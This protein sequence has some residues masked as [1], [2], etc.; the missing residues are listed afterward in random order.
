VDGLSG[1]QP[2]ELLNSISRL[3]PKGG[4]NLE[5]A[6]NQAYRT[7]A[8]FHN[9]QYSSRVI[10]LTDGAAN[11]G[12]IAPE[13]LTRL[14]ETQRRNGIAL[15]CFGIGWQGFNDTLLEEL[16]RNG[17]GR[18]GFL[19]SLEEVNTEFAEKLAGAF[20]PAASDVKVQIEFNPQRVKSHRLIGYANHRL[21]KEQFRDNTVDAA[22]LGSNESGN[23]LY[24]LETD[25]NGSGPISTMHLRYRIPGTEQYVESSR[26]LPFEAEVPALRD[27][28]E[29]LRLAAV[30]GVFGEWLAG[31]PFTEG[32]TLPSLAD[33]L[34]GVPEAFPYETRPQQLVWMIQKTS[35]LTGK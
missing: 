18:Y 21:K 20:R 9:N 29:S 8:K 12:N 17:D 22:E 28:P 23:A 34:H 27:A 35:G 3:L 26:T 31:N 32:I 30:A 25:P 11:L 7:A 19:N 2:D 16:S 4:T 5:E 15:D 24:I 33:L 13:A 14:V 10:L 6:L 1:G